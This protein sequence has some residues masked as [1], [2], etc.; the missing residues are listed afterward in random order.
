MFPQK[1]L[2]GVSSDDALAQ[3]HT[4]TLYQTAASG[5]SQEDSHGKSDEPALTADEGEIMMILAMTSLGRWQRNSGRLRCPS[6]PGT[7]L[8]RCS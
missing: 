5:Y 3:T 8:S 7:M 1:T 6:F 2:W 4:K